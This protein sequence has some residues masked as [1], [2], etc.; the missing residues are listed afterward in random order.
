MHGTLDR[1]RGGICAITRDTDE[2]QPFLIWSDSVI[3]NLGSSKGRMT[4]EDFLRGGCLV[5]DCPV[6]YGAF[7]DHSNGSIRHPFPEYDVFIV[8]VRFDL[9]LRF[10]VE[11]LKCTGSFKGDVVGFM[12]YIGANNDKTYL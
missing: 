10:N 8:D 9:L 3:D 7:C 11:D 5:G 12:R 4:I 1:E 6:V 2:N